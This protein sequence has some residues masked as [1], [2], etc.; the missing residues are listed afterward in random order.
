V[1]SIKNALIRHPLAAFFLLAYA[2]SWSIEL[3]VILAH[4][5]KGAHLEDGTL[6]LFLGSF[7]PSVAALIVSAASEGRA[8]V[9]RLLER[10]LPWR[11]SVAWTLI[12]LYGF[13]A[14]G[15][16]AITLLGVA[17]V[18]EALAQLPLALVAVP[19]NA[20]T[21]FLVLGPLGEELGWRG[22]A[23]PRLQAAYGALAGSGVLGLLWAYWH[24]PLMLFPDWRGDLPVGAFLIAYPL[25]T[26]PLTIIFTWVF[27]G[28]GGSAFVTTVLHAAFNYTVFFLNH[29]FD[30]GRYDALPLL[31]VMSG[32]FWLVAL[33]LRAVDGLRLGAERVHSARSK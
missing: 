13:L 3:P 24:A 4:L 1:Q 31:G 26:I 5:Q 8:G 16:P 32:L 14:L 23:L 33:G 12:A 30:L 6:L 10:L 2:I 29:R 21:S 27:N 20:L 17:S 15:L 22:Y 11:A 19:L 7:G 9:R 18:S 25:Y 28:S